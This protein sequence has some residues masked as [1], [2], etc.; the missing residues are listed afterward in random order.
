MKCVLSSVFSGQ[1]K[2]EICIEISFK[3]HFSPSTAGQNASYPILMK[4]YF[5]K[6][7]KP[8][9][10]CVQL[11]TTLKDFTD[12]MKIAVC[13]LQVLVVWGMQIFMWSLKLF[14]EI[15]SLSDKQLPYFA[16]FSHV[17]NNNQ[18]IGR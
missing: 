16:N 14:S 18:K 1:E 7:K 13:L 9:L 2:G 10:G 4:S 17:V 8:F 6:V 15:D 12:G 5:Q 3:F 11:V